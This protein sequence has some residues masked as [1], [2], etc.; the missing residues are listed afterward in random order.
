MSAYLSVEEGG[1]SSLCEQLLKSVFPRRWKSKQQGWRTQG[2]TEWVREREGGR[3]EMEPL[4]LPKPLKFDSPTL[5]KS[6]DH[7]SLPFFQVWGSYQRTPTPTLPLAPSFLSLA[8][9][10]TSFFFLCSHRRESGIMSSPP[11]LWS[12][13]GGNESKLQ[14][15]PSTSQAFHLILFKSL[16][17]FLHFFLCQDAQPPPIHQYPP[18]PHYSSDHGRIF[19]NRAL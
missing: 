5:N 18:P 9:I 15:L 3:A 17:I 10:L 16:R 11:Y 13:D 1:G 12:H 19:F 14:V 2:K 4:A 7:P 6:T 8:R